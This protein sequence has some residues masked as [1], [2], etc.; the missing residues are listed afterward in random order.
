MDLPIPTDYG[1]FEIEPKYE[2]HL[3]VDPMTATAMRVSAGGVR[4]T[5]VLGPVRWGVDYAAVSV[6]GGARLHAIT[7]ELGVAFYGL[8]LGLS[9][10]FTF[11]RREPAAPVDPMTSAMP[12]NRFEV[13]LDHRF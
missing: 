6:D 3:E 10:R 11:A 13:A 8:E 12:R 9:Y 5:H 7:P 2:R 4:V 1:A